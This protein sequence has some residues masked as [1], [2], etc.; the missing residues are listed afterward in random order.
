MKNQTPARKIIHVDMDAFYAAVEQRDNPELKG[1]PVV[2]GGKPNSRGVVSTASYEAR[3]YGIRSAMSLAE[4]SRRCPQAIFLPVNGAKYVS[5]SR[6]IQEI[7]CRYTP[8]VEPLSLDEA[9]LDVTGSMS[10]FGSALSIAGDI[11]DRIKAELNLTA[12]VGVASNKFLAKVASDLRKPDGL[13]VVDPGRTQEFLDPLPV[14]RVWGVGRKTAERLRGLNVKTIRDIR[15]LDEGYLL[16][17]FGSMGSQLYLLARGIDD[18]PVETGREAKSIGREITFDIDVIDREVLIGRLLKL[19]ISVGRR[20]RK[21]ALKTRTVTLKLRYDDFRT[22][23]RS[24]TLDHLTTLDEEIYA[25]ACVL[26]EEVSP[27]TPIRLIGVSLHN[28]TDEEEPQLSLFG[29]G[30]EEKEKLAE[31]I[32]A[33]KD[34]FGEKSITRARLVKPKN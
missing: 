1:K 25:T 18:R 12:S 22:I 32:D 13:V 26:L 21:E 4:A 15:S 5:V 8:V 10:L 30:K 2:V 34:K 17:L 31:V 24:K 19:S 9:F 20:L 29:E 23:T 16:K 27:K 7:F 11:K 3:T 33:V 6:Q 28:L 14:E